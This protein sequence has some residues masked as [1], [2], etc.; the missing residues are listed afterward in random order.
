[1]FKIIVVVILVILLVLIFELV[2]I[3]N[4]WNGEIFFL[5]FF[6]VFGCF[7]KV[8]NILGN[9]CNWMNLELIVKKNL[10]VNN[11]LIKY[12][13]YIKLVLIWINFL[14][15][16]GIKLLKFFKINFLYFLYELCIFYKIRL[17]WNFSKYRD[18]LLFFI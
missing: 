8:L 17:N 6:K 2:L 9:I 12:W 13:D 16:L 18:I 10:V 14:N 5:L 4:V 11:R 3:V 1:M 7:I 15:Y